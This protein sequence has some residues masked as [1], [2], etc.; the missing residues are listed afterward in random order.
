MRSYLRFLL[1]FALRDEEIR[2]SPTIVQIRHAETLR[3]IAEDPNYVP[4]PDEDAND[5][6]L[7]PL[8]L[9]PLVKLQAEI[10]ITGK[11][12]NRKYKVITV[13]ELEQ[14]QQDFMSVVKNLHDTTR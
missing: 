12:R 7:I 10:Q 6:D 2:Q 5:L 9:E 11:M 3:L 1:S 4:D 8:Q 13:P 14:M